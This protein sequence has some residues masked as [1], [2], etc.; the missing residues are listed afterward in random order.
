VFL[1]SDRFFK[2][3]TDQTLADAWLRA[4]T[5]TGLLYALAAQSP[6]LLLSMV[7]LFISA[8]TESIS[9]VTQTELLHIRTD[10]TYREEI[11]AFRYITRN[12]GKA[13]C[14]IVVGAIITL[15]GVST[16]LTLVGVTMVGLAASV[17]LYLSLSTQRLPLPQ[18]ASA[19]T[20]MAMQRMATGWLMLGG[21]MHDM[22]EPIFQIQTT[23][24]PLDESKEHDPDK[25]VQ[26]PRIQPYSL[27]TGRL[28]LW[29]ES[30]DTTVLRVLPKRF[31][32]RNNEDNYKVSED[33]PDKT[34]VR[35]RK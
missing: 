6:Y 28:S 31:M 27:Y 7:L 35:P 17:W 2:R 23:S 34:I 21:D 13:L 29:Q 30:G 33:D 24:L 19:D 20:A 26:L 9:G 11:Y 15:A 12:V 4:I 22:H 3:R 10:D 18:V 25:T 8:V 16:A 5:L 32:Q 14:T 1:R